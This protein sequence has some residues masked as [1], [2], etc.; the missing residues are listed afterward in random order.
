MNYQTFQYFMHD[1][2]Q[3]FRF[4]LAGT[5]SNEDA[6]R[7][8]QDWH[9]A[10]SM[11]GNRLLI[12]DITFVTRVDQEGRGL[13]AHWYSQGAQ[14]VAKSK[15]SHELAETIIGK[16]LSDVPSAGVNRTWLPFHTSFSTPKLICTRIGQ[17][18]CRV[19]WQV[20]N[21]R[22]VLCIFLGGG[23]FF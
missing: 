21:F 17:A 12:V 2:P 20:P 8:Q 5:L 13:L 10:S 9:A 18:I 19:P 11:I 4:E 1:G 23:T 22:A 6:R 14:L 3:A 7:L 16:P 15:A